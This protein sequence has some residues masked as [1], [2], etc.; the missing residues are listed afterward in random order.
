MSFWG[1]ADQCFPIKNS[2]DTEPSKIYA[3]QCRWP[4]NYPYYFSRKISCFKA[5]QF[6]EN[7]VSGK[8]FATMHLR[9][10]CLEFPEFRIWIQTIYFRILDHSL[11]EMN[12][13]SLNRS[14]LRASCA[15]K[16]RYHLSLFRVYNMNLHSEYKLCHTFCSCCKNS[17]NNTITKIWVMQ[18]CLVLNDLVGC[19]QKVT[20]PFGRELLTKNIKLQN[21]ILLRV[22]FNEIV[23]YRTY[24]DSRMDSKR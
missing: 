18:Y 11:K 5:L 6:R 22:T 9:K 24:L 19:T 17:L 21:S 14:N 7:L 13:H 3:K 10:N 23:S 2:A 16:N 1:R 15:V 8:M 20:Q 4:V 12:L